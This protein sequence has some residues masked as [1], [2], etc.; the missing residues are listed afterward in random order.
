MSK[1]GIA[2]LKLILSTGVYADVHFLVGD[3]DAK[4]LVSAHKYILKFASDVFEAMFRFDAMKDQGEN[5]SANCSVIEVPDV[6]AA[7]FKVM[8]SFIY[9]EDLCE[10]NGDNA[11][12]VIYAAKKYNIP[13]LVRPSLQIPISELRNVF[14]AYAQARLFNLEDFANCCLSYIDKNVDILLKSDGFLQIDQK[15]LCEIISPENHRQMLGPALFKIRFPLFSQEDFLEKIVPSGILSTNEVMGIEQYHTNPNFCGISC[16]L[17]Y[18]LQFP[19]HER[20]EAFGTL[21][22]DIEK[23]SEFAREAVRSSRFS[24]EMCI[25]GLSWRI[26]A[27][28]K[29]KNGSTDNEK[30]L[31][32][33]LFCTE[34]KEDSN[35]RCRVHSATFRIVSQKKVAENA[36]GILCDHVF[37]NKFTGC[38]IPNFISF[39]ELMDPSNGFYDRGEDKVT[40]TID[41][42]IKRE[43]MYKFLLNQS[44]SNGTLFMDIEKVS[45]FAREVI[46]SERKN[47]IATHIKG[48]PWKIVAQLTGGTDKKK[49][50][51]IFLLCA[52]PKEENWSCECSA[53]IRIVSQKCDVAD[54]RAGFNEKLLNNEA[55]GCGCFNLF[56]FAQLIDPSSGFYNKNEDKMTFAIDFSVKE[57]KTDK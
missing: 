38:G 8:L 26:W 44:K 2:G 54:Y 46:G 18:P 20:I 42:T 33:Y 51:G 9:T 24:E 34:P 40:L 22:M 3:G 35:W 37:N 28:I 16:G 52:A 14:L 50:L 15:L 21:L 53:I 47:E 7:A 39:A 57:A 12:A 23:V 4:E 11:M 25:N 19:S 1:A 27:Q 36:I 32:I 10:L 17:L 43:K 29:T 49:I 45:E 41:L 30:Y 5:V 48:L 6:E 55:R 31:G 13:G 56:P